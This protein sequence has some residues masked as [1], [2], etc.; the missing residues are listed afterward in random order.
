MYSVEKIKLFLI[1][2]NINFEIEKRF[3]TCKNKL[4][5]PFDFYN[6]EF[7]K[8]SFKKLPCGFLLYTPPVCTCEFVS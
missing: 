8:K 1:K 3:D 5:L 4:C 7:T 2:N 6:F